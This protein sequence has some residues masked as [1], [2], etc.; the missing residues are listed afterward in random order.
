MGINH[1]A[2]PTL[3]GI[4]FSRDRAMQLDATLRSL[5]RHCSDASLFD[6]HVLYAASTARFRTQYE[7]L[8]REWSHE[9]GIRFHAEREFRCDFLKLLGLAGNHRGPFL[10][11]RQRVVGRV[12]RSLNRAPTVQAPWE[13]LLFLVDDNIFVRSFSLSDACMALRDDPLA[14]GF[15]LRLGRNTT[16]CY[17]LRKSQEPPQFEAADRATLAFDWTDAECDFGYP[18]EVSSSLYT[19]KA[20]AGLLTTEDYSN[21]N[22]LESALARSASR[23]GGTRGRPHLLCFPQSVTFC[24]AVNR[25][26]TTYQN[27][28]GDAPEFAADALADS[29]DSGLR[30]DISAFDGFLPDACHSNIP[31]TFA[32]I[33]D[34]RGPGPTVSIMQEPEDLT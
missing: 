17:S 3:V 7:N 30:I 21:P 18:L 24:N 27:R 26:Q 20:I 19:A 29:F 12:H 13:L 8:A 32:A 23:F 28:S 34:L 31:V 33:A 25:V 4:V 6:L 5:F 16:S 1:S 10:A 11:L 15:S 14:I 22:T 2:E 9:G